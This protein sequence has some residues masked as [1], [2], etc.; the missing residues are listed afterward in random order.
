MV[1]EGV[2]RLVQAP[3]ARVL[4]V[5]R[6]L[7]LPRQVVTQTLRLLHARVRLGGSLRQLPLWVSE[8]VCVCAGCRG[9]CVR[10]CAQRQRVRNKS[11]TTTFKT[12]RLLL[13]PDHVPLRVGQPRARG[14]DGPRHVAQDLRVPVRGILRGPLRLVGQLLLPLLL[15]LRVLQR[16][17]QAAL[18]RLRRLRRLQGVRGAARGVLGLA[19]G[20]GGTRLRLTLAL[21]LRL[22]LTLLVGAELADTIRLAGL[23]GGCAWW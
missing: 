1:V 18:R 19:G 13:R 20:L 12:Y 17:Q 6:V 10:R 4:T 8:T 9:V 21:L 14:L 2:P 16:L 3:L 5:T 7:Q 22:Q 11:T 23:C 15:A